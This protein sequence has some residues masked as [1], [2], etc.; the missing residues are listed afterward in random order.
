MLSSSSFYWAHLVYFV[1]NC[2]FVCGKEEIQPQTICS[3]GDMISIHTR[4][5]FPHVIFTFFCSAFAYDCSRSINGIIIINVY[6]GNVIDN[7]I[8]LAANQVWNRLNATNV[9]WRY[10]DDELILYGAFLCLITQNAL[11]A[12]DLSSLIY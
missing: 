3:N 10:S 1:Y 5:T 8:K 9:R 11:N 6:H 2:V 12:Y 4:R 7:G